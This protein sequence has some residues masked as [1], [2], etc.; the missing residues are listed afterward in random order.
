MCKGKRDALPNTHK[1]ITATYIQPSSSSV[2]SITQPIKTTTLP[3]SSSTASLTS[4][5]SSATVT[6]LTTGDLL[7]DSSTFVT[8][9]LAS[10]A[11]GSPAQ[12]STPALPDSAQSPT[13]TPVLSKQ[14]IAG[15]SAASVGGAAI[16]A[17]LII[18]CTCWRRR[19]QRQRDSD[20]LPFQADPGTPKFGLRRPP[21]RGQ[22]EFSKSKSSNGQSPYGTWTKIPPQIP[23]RPA[24]SD[25]YM[26]S[27]RSIMPSTIGVAVSPDGSNAVPK[28]NSR[29]LPD[30][31]TLT[32][33]TSQVAELPIGASSLKPPLPIYAQMSRQST[34]TQFEED[35]YSPAD[36]TYG[37]GSTDRILSPQI[38]MPSTIRVVSPANIPPAFFVT[39]NYPTNPN[40]APP[41]IYNRQNN[42]P[43]PPNLNI[44]TA[45]NYYVKPL[46]INRGVGS[47]S[48]PRPTPEGGLQLQVPSRTTSQAAS[49]HVTQAS[50]VYSGASNTPYTNA[51]STD[52]LSSNQ[53]PL[54]YPPHPKSDLRSQRKSYQQPGPYDRASTGSFTSF[55]DSDI[56]SPDDERNPGARGTIMMDLSPVVESPASGRSPVS[57]PRIPPRMSSQPTPTIR[58]VPPPPQPDFASVFSSGTSA[59][60][61]TTGR[62]NSNLRTNKPWQAAEIAAARQRRMSQAQAQAQLQAQTQAQTQAQAPQQQVTYPQPLLTPTKQPVPKLASPFQPRPSNQGQAPVRM[63]TGSP[64][65]TH[66]RQRSRDYIAPSAHFNSKH[67]RNNSGSASIASQ[68]S[69]NSSLL[70]KRL[71]TEKAAAFQLHTKTLEEKPQSKWRVLDE[72][73][74]EA[75]RDPSWRPQLAQFEGRGKEKR[76]EVRTRDI[77]RE[78]GLPRTP[79]WVPKLTPTRRGDDLFLSVA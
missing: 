53:F 46:N 26:F 44:T 5:S 58:M 32:L 65:R 18:F 7:T 15:I 31:P 22:S 76:T 71:G 12:T 37:R 35:E 9:A 17:G 48:R 41:A 21:L 62:E 78:D 55:A 34:A 24:A 73:E 68:N 13:P 39:S 29:L 30:K 33:N 6:S 67:L 64:S 11:S 16:I 60:K 2:V 27:R 10:R 77:A 74:R 70:A 54:T 36:D 4:S 50:S 52:R 75:A 49:R 43:Y 66:T 72:A 8:S 63:N 40:P 59:S 42:G 19:R 47:F 1:T 25:P 56:A 51:P 61:N 20:V 57:Y 38:P 3:N 69:S 79:G 23:P 14:Q 45:P 28:R